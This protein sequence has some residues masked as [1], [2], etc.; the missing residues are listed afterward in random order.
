MPI[1]FQHR[2]KALRVTCNMRIVSLGSRDKVN[3]NAPIG[4]ICKIESDPKAIARR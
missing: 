3:L 4:D 1:Y 2:N